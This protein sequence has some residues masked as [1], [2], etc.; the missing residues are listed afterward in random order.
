MVKCILEYKELFFRKTDFSLISG[1]RF[2]DLRDRALDVDSQS[3]SKSGASKDSKLRQKYFSKNNEIVGKDL[4]DFL[5]C[6]TVSQDR[7]EKVGRETSDNK[8]SDA[9]ATISKKMQVRKAGYKDVEPVPCPVEDR[10]K[11]ALLYVVNMFL[12]GTQY[13]HGIA[14]DLWH[15]VENLSE[16]N[17]YPWG[18]RVYKAT[19]FQSDSAIKSQMKKETDGNIISK[20]TVNPKGM[21]QV[22]V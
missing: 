18:E 10:V 5:F 22:L 1:L 19:L 15:L 8:T 21:P 6:K 7:V 17:N 20:P 2:R 4:Y 11:V 14:D 3:G 16:F 9:S 12:L 13:I